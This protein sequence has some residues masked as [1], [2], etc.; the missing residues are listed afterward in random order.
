MATQT[1]PKPDL[2]LQDLYEELG[3]TIAIMPTN[4]DIKRVHMRQIQECEDQAANHKR[5][6]D[7][8]EAKTAKLDKK[9]QDLIRTIRKVIAGEN[10]LVA[11]L[12]IRGTNE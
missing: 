4:E 10:P 1:T 9:S 7:A 11:Y 8:L 3:K 12:A 6:V 2:S 5:E